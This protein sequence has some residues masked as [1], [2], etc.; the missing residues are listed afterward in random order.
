[1]QVNIYTKDADNQYLSLDFSLR[2]FVCGCEHADCSITL[3]DNR[4]LKGLQTYRQL[5]GGPVHLTSA[6]RCQRHNADVGGTPHSY[7]MKGM[8]ADIAVADLL[9]RREQQ[10][11]LQTIFDKV[12]YYE[13]KGIF[14][15]H[16]LHKERI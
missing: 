10:R 13:D 9:P 6:F 11:I 14:H 16:N 1:M 2:E 12:I 5:V 15:V 8:A 3:I 7:H 4:L